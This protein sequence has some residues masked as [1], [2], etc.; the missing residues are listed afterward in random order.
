MSS[1][2]GRNGKALSLLIVWSLAVGGVFTVLLALSPP[3]SAAPCD[4]VSGVITGDWTISTVQVCEDIVY[5][6]D[7]TI[8]INAGGS[9]TLVNGG[10]RFAKD[11]SHASY[12]LNVNSNGA[13]IL[14]NSILTTERAT[15]RRYVRI[16]REIATTSSTST[17]SGSATGN[18]DGCAIRPLACAGRMGGSGVSWVP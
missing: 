1:R 4:A 15:V 2:P 16:S 18:T 5:T 9:L 6:V 13:L 11:A 14:D 3:A 8:T 12:S 17:E 10:L 7:G